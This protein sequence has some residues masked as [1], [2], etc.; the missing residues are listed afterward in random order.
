MG[1]LLIIDP[2]FTYGGAQTA[3]LHLAGWITRGGVQVVLAVRGANSQL[4]ASASA[5]GVP[6]QVYQGPRV[7]WERPREFLGI[8][9]PWDDW[10]SSLAHDAGYGTVVVNLPGIDMGHAVVR[11]LRRGGH[12]VCGF[13]HL[14]YPMARLVGPSLANRLRDCLSDYLHFAPY[15]NIVVVSDAGRDVVLARGR[16][17]PPVA[18]VPNGPPCPIVA[19]CGDPTGAALDALRSIRAAKK[20]GRPVAI[21]VGRIELVHKNQLVLIQ[22]LSMLPPQERP[23]LVLVGSGPDLAVVAEAAASCLESVMFAGWT[24]R[25]D[26]FLELADGMMLPS[27]FEQHPMVIEE[28]LMYGIPIWVSTIPSL[29]AIEGISGHVDPSDTVGWSDALLSVR[30]SSEVRRPDEG[31]RGRRGA[32]WARRFLQAVQG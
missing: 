20:A 3:M 15:H 2:S 26:L 18:T 21:C 4:V 10:V 1:K 30:P 16:R 29:A 19:P 31:I 7:P 9:G 22:A 14:P 23:L 11:A 25:V 24:D 27:W 12:R 6:C 5:H 17:C 8:G 13:L 32:D 28:A